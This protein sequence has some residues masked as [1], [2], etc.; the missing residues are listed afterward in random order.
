M[1]KLDVVWANLL[2]FQII[3]FG[4]VFDIWLRIQGVEARTA[5]YIITTGAL[6]IITPVLWGVV[7]QWVLED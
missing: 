7:Y 4:F 1:E 2:G 6:I 3:I 5:D